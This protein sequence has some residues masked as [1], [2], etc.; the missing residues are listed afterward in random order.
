MKTIRAVLFFIFF[1]CASQLTNAQAFTVTFPINN[2]I[3]L[4]EESVIVIRFENKVNQT[5]FIIESD[6]F[7]NIEFDFKKS[8]SNAIVNLIPRT[9]FF[10]GDRIRVR[11]INHEILVEFTVR[12]RKVNSDY[13]NE[14]IA[15]VLRVIPSFTI[16][17]NVTSS[18]DPIFF[19]NGG[20]PGDRFMSIIQSD[21]SEIFSQAENQVQNFDLQPSGYLS[22]FDK[23]NDWFVLMD[24]SYSVID[25]IQGASGLIADFHEFI[26]LPNGN[27]LL[28]SEDPQITDLTAIGGITNVSVVGNVIQII[29]DN[30]ILLFNWRSWDYINV[31]ETSIN[32]AGASYVDFMHVNAIDYDLDGNIIVSA[33]NLNQVFKINRLNGNFKWRLGGTLGDLAIINDPDQ[34]SLQHDCRI[35]P[36]GHLTVFDNGVNHSIPLAKAK[37]YIIDTL[38]NTATLIWSFSNPNGQPSSKTGNAQRLPNGNTFINWG[39]RNNVVDPNFTEVNSSGD[40]VY[41]FRFTASSG[42]SCYRARRHPWNLTTSLPEFKPLIVTPFP[43]PA[44]N[45]ILFKASEKID[46]IVVYNLSGKQVLNVSNSNEIVIESLAS[47]LYLVQLRIGGTSYNTKFIKQ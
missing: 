4:H 44:T 17:T 34:L 3:N 29:D 39:A 12:G 25:T 7:N 23:I 5:D 40:I 18:I 30:D 1:I 31:E 28:M 45:S 32:V 13:E 35:L 43:N 2:S 20:S 38:L 22:Y 37:E 24:S 47:G 15:P 9:P 46:L 33:R 16:D 8:E 10:L 41:Q 42:Y 21:G 36:N 27:S 14:D 11:N 19:R 26:H 6:I